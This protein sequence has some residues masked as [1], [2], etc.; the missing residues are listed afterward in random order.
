MLALIRAFAKSWVAAVLIGVLI[1]SFAVFG[2]GDV[3]KTRVPHEVIKAGD[4]S[5]S[6]ETF[7]SE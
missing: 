1:V 5:V 2:I 4:R 6:V 7:R 3:F